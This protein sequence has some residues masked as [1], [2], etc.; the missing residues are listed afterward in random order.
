MGCPR[1]PESQPDR[2]FSLNLPRKGY[3]SFGPTWFRPHLCLLG[4]LPVWRQAMPPGS[5]TAGSVSLLGIYLCLRA[6]GIQ[7]VAAPC[8]TDLLDS[9]PPWSG[10]CCPWSLH[11]WSGDGGGNREALSGPWR[12]HQRDTNFRLLLGPI[13]PKISGLF[14]SLA[15]IL[16]PWEPC[17][18]WG[19]TLTLEAS[20]SDSF[21]SHPIFN[22]H[23]LTRTAHGKS[24]SVLPWAFVLLWSN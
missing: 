17:I 24:W 12:S 20:N 8:G 2:A 9:I 13:L 14:V 5:F 23:Q 3:L 21:Q 11:L 4:L 16:I 18:N 6:D 22:L 19:E 10:R 7:W 1:E 15:W